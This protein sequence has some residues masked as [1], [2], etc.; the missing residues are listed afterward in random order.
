MFPIGAM[1]QH[2]CSVLVQ[3]ENRKRECENIFNQVRLLLLCW[4]VCYLP[5]LDG[6]LQRPDQLT[7]D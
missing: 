1:P 3:T 5:L 2:S 6:L 4:H 7:H